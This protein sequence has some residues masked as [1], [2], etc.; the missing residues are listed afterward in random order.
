MF[1]TQGLDLRVMCGDQWAYARKLLPDAGQTDFTARLLETR[2]N[3]GKRFSY[4]LR[5]EAGSAGRRQWGFKTS[6]LEP[7]AARIYD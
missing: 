3:K 1:T 4:S 5:V 6:T 7:L 2:G